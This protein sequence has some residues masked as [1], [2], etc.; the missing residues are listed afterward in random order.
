MHLSIPEIKVCNAK[1]EISV[2]QKNPS[3]KLPKQ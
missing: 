1:G 2:G 3:I